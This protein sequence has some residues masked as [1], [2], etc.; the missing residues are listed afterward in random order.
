MEEI[1]DMLVSIEAKI[2]NIE[3]ELEKRTTA[4]NKSLDYI[5]PK[6]ESEFIGEIKL[7]IENGLYFRLLDPNGDGN[8]DYTKNGNFV[9]NSNG[10]ITTIDGFKL[11]PEIQIPESISKFEVNTSGNVMVTLLD[12]T[13]EAIGNINPARFSKPEFLEPVG[14]GKYR[15]T[16]KS[17][18]AEIIIDSTITDKS[19]DDSIRSIVNKNNKAVMFNAFKLNN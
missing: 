3:T 14:N 7:E 16:D 9:V 18:P 17:L 1:K 12:G 11:V 5:I 15:E 19:N 4:I 13:T 6:I 8:F 2:D 10:F